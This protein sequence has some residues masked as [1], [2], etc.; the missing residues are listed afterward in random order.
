MLVAVSS[1]APD[2]P[3]LDSAGAL[4]RVWWDVRADVQ[5]TRSKLQRS[6]TS[7]CSCASKLRLASAAPWNTKQKPAMIGRRSKVAQRQPISRSGPRVGRVSS[8][9][10]RLTC[11][12]DSFCC[13]CRV[14]G[15][16]GTSSRAC[17]KEHKRP[18][19]YKLHKADTVEMRFLFAVRSPPFWVSGYYTKWR[20]QGQFS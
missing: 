15:S 18:W 7:L 4:L 16:S 12:P 14:G 3:F 19:P 20:I 9:V 11:F 6:F 10:P 5:L 13:C 2:F 1:L 8:N 17:D